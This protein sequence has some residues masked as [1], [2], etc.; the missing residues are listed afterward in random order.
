MS[1]GIDVTLNNWLIGGAVKRDK[2]KTGTTKR[3]YVIAYVGETKLS[4]WHAWVPQPCI[5]ID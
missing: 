1:L 2:N 4:A 5:E 3:T